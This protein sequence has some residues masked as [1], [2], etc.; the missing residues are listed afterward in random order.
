[1]PLNRT[2]IQQQAEKH[3]AAGKIEAAV[4]QYKKLVDDNPRDL[5]TLNKIGDL[6]VR[7]NRKVEAIGTFHRI[8]EIYAEDGFFL[9]AIAIYKKI[10]KIDPASIEIMQR[11]AELYSRQGLKTEARSQYVAVAQAHVKRGRPQEA[12]QCYEALAA[13]EPESIQHRMALAELKAKCGMHTEAAGTLLALGIELEKK[14]NSKE[15]SRIYEL[16]FKTSQ[17]DPGVAER[18]GMALIGSGQH[19]R[20]I[21]IAEKILAGHPDSGAMMEVRGLALEAAG[22]KE[23]A[24]VALKLSLDSD[25]ERCGALVALARLLADR[26]APDDAVETL[27]GGMEII[28]DGGK[29]QDAA[30][31]LE[32]LLAE[33]PSYRPGLEAL[34]RMHSLSGDTRAAV[35]AGKQ[36]VEASLSGGHRN[37]ALAVARRLVE[38]EPGVGEHAERVARIEAADESPEAGEEPEVTGE[39]ETD[40]VDVVDLDAGVE[41]EPEPPVPEAPVPAAEA[42]IEIEEEVVEGFE[43]ELPA[44]PPEVAPVERSLTSEDEEFIAERVTEADVFIKYGLTDRAIEQLAAIAQRFPWHITTRA[45]LRELYLEE[46]NRPRAAVEA[47]EI[48]KVRLQEGD[49]EGAAAA[50]EDARKIDTACPAIASLQA[51]LSGGT[52]DASEFSASVMPSSDTPAGEQDSLEIE[53]EPA[54]L[55]E[56]PEAAAVARDESEEDSVPMAAVPAEAPPEGM[57][58]DPFDLAAA[59]DVSLFGGEAP[60]EAGE[61][62]AVVEE[63]EATPE[64]HSLDEIVSAFKKGIEKQVGA[65]DFET[66]YN[67]GIA[68]KEMGLVDEAIAEFQFAAKSDSLLASCC[69]MLGMCF[70][71]KGMNPIAVKWYRRGLDSVAGSGQEEELNGLR[72]DLAEVLEAMGEI[73]QARDLLTEVYGVNSRYRDVADRMKALEARLHS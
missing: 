20:A 16:A 30:Q 26:G 68:Y 71:E 2:K 59:L 10:T 14:G 44:V 4:E 18:L 56:E 21:E 53:E 50:L 51:M 48:G 43:P 9:K 70:R 8:A 61:G 40:I 67:L 57:E 52:M 23:E 31:V 33:N 15:S 41:A 54:S 58:E 13:M 27:S 37:E 11:L 69:S 63:L 42:E 36:L 19:E 49:R 73:Q 64:A 6:Y 60:G 12:I 46:G 45:R 29:V 32:S 65:E 66:H 5:G 17:G 39:V 35:E 28:T 7:L 3:V 22:R 55:A 62:D 47:A 24:E 34:Y 1:M 38:M 25:P 72:Y